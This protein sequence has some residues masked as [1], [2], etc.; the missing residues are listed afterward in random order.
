VPSQG[1]RAERRHARQDHDDVGRH[2]PRPEE[3][4][5]GEDRPD[6]AG[7]RDQREQGT[8]DLDVD[9]S[10]DRGGQPV[11]PRP[12][13]D[14][15]G[16][17]R[18]REHRGPAQRAGVPVDEDAEQP[19]EA[20]DLVCDVVRPGR[21]AARQAR[22]DRGEPAEDAV[23]DRDVDD[24]RGQDELERDESGQRPLAP[25]Q[26]APEGNRDDRPG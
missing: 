9:L 8:G 24:R 13:Q 7:D 21:R 11:P 1:D 17:D 14:P 15:D 20:G 3:R 19:G 16:D 4:R 26:P 12:V 6:D 2:E 22:R 25:S 18:E 10:G 23:V 5:P